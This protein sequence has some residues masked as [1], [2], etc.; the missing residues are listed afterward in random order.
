MPRTKRPKTKKPRIFTPSLSKRN[1]PSSQVT[2]LSVTRSAP[3]P[4]PSELAGYESI[5]PGAAERIFALVENQSNHRQ[6]L[7]NKALSIE[8]R[9]SLLGL[10]TGGVIGI[11]GL[12]IAGFCIY[13]GHDKAG[14]ALGGGTLVSL[15]GP[16]IYGTRQRRIEREQKYLSDQKQSKKQR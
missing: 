2:Q 4:H 1:L 12:C 11:V 13:A 10:I 15:V 16:F 14:M 3:L 8:G 6:G 7:E 9:N 5:L